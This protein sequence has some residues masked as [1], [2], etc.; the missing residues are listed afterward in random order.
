MRPLETGLMVL[1]RE[2]GGR[3]LSRRV[4]LATRK[5]EQMSIA[6]LD[7]ARRVSDLCLERVTLPPLIPVGEAL[8][9]PFDSGWQQW[10]MAVR[11]QERMN[12]ADS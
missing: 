1:T 9:L 10:D 11:L 5:G 12:H 8:E 6:N 7:E 3:R 4:R 2:R